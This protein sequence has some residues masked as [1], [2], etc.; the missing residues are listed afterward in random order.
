[1]SIVRKTKSVELLKNTFHESLNAFSVVE[2]IDRF[3]NEMN[4]TTI[5][6]IL[7]KLEQDGFVHS[8]LGMD[9]LKWYAKCN[10]CSSH[11]HIDTHPHFQ[12]QKCGRLDCL[13]TDISIP[14]I[15][16]R[17]V[18]FAQVLLVGECEKCFKLN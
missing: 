1:M 13:E 2:L 3:K 16:N 10:E 17:R 11:H 18:N 15:A 4:K 14:S 12:C 7:D 9:G 5:Y 6:R 8:F